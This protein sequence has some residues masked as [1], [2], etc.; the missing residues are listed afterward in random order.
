MPPSPDASDPGADSDAA[1]LLDE[2][3]RVF[4][5]EPPIVFKSL[6]LQPDSWRRRFR[7][8]RVKCHQ[9]QAANAQLVQELSQTR[10]DLQRTTQELRQ[11][12]SSRGWQLLHRVR[13]TVERIRRRISRRLRF[14]FQLVRGS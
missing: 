10:S 9:V 3:N 4:A 7:I 12:K 11:L 14:P 5:A 1:V 8:L 13:Q 2:L 6:K